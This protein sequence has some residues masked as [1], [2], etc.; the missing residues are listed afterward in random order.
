MLEPKQANGGR[1]PSHGSASLRVAVHDPSPAYRRGLELALR[2]AGLVVE[3]PEDPR[4]WGREPGLRV[5]V[6]TCTSVNDLDQ[7]AALHV[8]K[9]DL[10]IIAVLV[11]PS[12]ASYR[13][14]L[15]RGLS[16]VERDAPLDCIVDA[17]RAAASQRT[18]LPNSVARALARGTVPTEQ[19]RIRGDQQAWLRQLAAGATVKQLAAAVGYSE[20]AMHRHLQR[21]YRQLDAGNRTDA[22]LQA[23]RMGMIE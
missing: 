11:D 21:L 23:M 16:A 4:C 20:R 2:D 5:V 19:S 18:V 13:G 3:H 1:P 7:L 17:V 8:A 10:P 14:A 15:A 12:P 9:P 6:S 22:L